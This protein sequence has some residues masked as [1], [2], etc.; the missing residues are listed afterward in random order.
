MPALLFRDRLWWRELPPPCEQFCLSD[1]ASVPSPSLF[2]TQQSSIC[3]LHSTKKPYY[4]LLTDC[5][6]IQLILPGGKRKLN[7]A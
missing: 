5:D 1:K 7:I 6:V 4:Y 3:N 2:R